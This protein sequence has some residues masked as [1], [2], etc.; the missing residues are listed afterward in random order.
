MTAP[1]PSPDP[2]VPRVLLFGHRGAGKSALIG[3][4]LQAGETQGETLRGEVVHSS[5]E[6]PRIR[7]AVYSGTKL[8]PSQR[9]LVSYTV[10][11]RPWRVGTKPVGDPLTVILD[12]CD[13]KAAE[14]LLENPEPITRRDP[15]SPVAKAIVGADAIVLLVDAASTDAEMAEAFAEFDTFLKV[16]GSA[17]TDAREVGGFPVLLV[18]TQC[19]RLAR[20][21]DT[22][23]VWQARVDDRTDAAW[24]AFDA[25][26]K[27]ADPHDGPAPFLAFGS[28]DVTVFAV[29][30]R[31]PALPDAA[32]PANQPYQVAELFRDCFAEAKAHRARVRASDTR[33]KWTIR[34]AMTALTVLFTGLATVAIFPPHPAGPALA[35]KVRL[36]LAGERPAAV[37]LADGEIDRN[38]N[39]L[40]RFKSDSEFPTLEPDLRVLVE[41][42]LKEIEDYDAF[43]GK[44]ADATAPASARSLP[45]LAKIRAVLL[46][47]LAL[48]PEYAWG[49]TAAAELR[50]KWL[51]DADA[52]EAAEKVLVETYRGYDR[53][54]TALMLRRNFD[55]GWQSDLAALVA[56]A[57]RPPFPLGD[58]LPGSFAVE[59]PRGE[60]VTYRVP[61]EFDEVYHARRYWL[62]T[63]DQL[64][65]LWD[66]A[67]ALGAT[68]IPD[69]VLVLPE[70]NG[71]NTA[72]LPGERL[73]RLDEFVKR[74]WDARGDV[75]GE[76]KR[77]TEGY[78]EW[79]V[80]NFPDPVRSDLAARLQKSI[81]TGTRHVHTLMKVQ[82]TLAGWKAL[83]ATLSDPAYQEWGRF[84]HLLARLQD[85][86][87]PNP[88]AELK[89]FLSDLDTKKFELDLH[90]FELTI[91]LDLTAGLE[92]VEPTGPLTITIA[93][94]Q[95][96]PQTY[97]FAVGKGDRRDNAMLYRLT[98][99]GSGKIAYFA[100]DDLRAELLVKAGAQQ[101][102]LLWELG[103]SNTFRFDRL[104]REPRLTKATGGTEPA[105]GVKLVPSAGSTVPKL[106][107][108]M[109][110]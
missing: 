7:Y 68:G 1:E 6:L 34:L 3:A 85:P 50:R 26:L 31:R 54:G 21:G 60:V 32:A 30:V 52:I 74:Q 86:A 20:P 103:G 35:D 63:R 89:A 93:H 19:D 15:N 73:R 42:R 55:A 78:P 102:A 94:G 84:L 14:S 59:Q 13:G 57:D 9:E 70:P 87:A 97:K 10:R 11:L 4:L 64:W 5:T 99:E 44:L 39:T 92:R 22:T 27:D 71:T 65:H 91:P 23:R 98:A 16:V 106:P 41:S 72:M 108:L 12:D 2:A 8:E 75:G 69:P 62:Q 17:K 79:A 81:A 61:Y 109:P 82:D 67:T 105:T 37:R 48:P 56:K 77:P 95:D 53:D 90:G 96:K 104:S 100:G 76:L 29:A 33:L 40:L 18:L 66:A 83:A 24:K 80:P 43:R 58:P 88:V 51:A 107:V 110:K 28:V 38:R 45:D 25:F 49:E 46:T 36:Y 47:T 101:L